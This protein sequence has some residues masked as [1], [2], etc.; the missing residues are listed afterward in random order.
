MNLLI[1]KTFTVNAILFSRVICIKGKMQK[2]VLKIRELLNLVKVTQSC[3]TL[4]E[5]GLY[6]PRNSPGQ[7]TAVGR[8]SL[9]Q[10][11]NLNS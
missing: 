1:L 3:P 8:L 2:I 6:S 7:N 9:L 4:Y 11:L 5:N 10:G